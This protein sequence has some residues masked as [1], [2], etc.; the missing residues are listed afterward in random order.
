MSYTPL[1]IGNDL[2]DEVGNHLSIKSNDGDIANYMS[3]E[4]HG[5]G[6]AC[7]GK[8]FFD[9]YIDN[10]Y[11][12]GIPK[13]R[14]IK[15][16]V[17]E[18]YV[19][20]MLTN[21]DP[22]INYNIMDFVNWMYQY[23]NY[24]IL[25]HITGKLTSDKFDD[26][27]NPK[28]KPE[29]MSP[30][31]YV[32]TVNLVFKGGT[33]MH[34][35][36]NQIRTTMDHELAK[37][38]HENNTADIQRLEQAI[39][40]LVSMEDNFKPSDTDMCLDITASDNRRY[41]CICYAASDLIIKSME[42][43]S[44]DLEHLW[45][46]GHNQTPLNNL[47][48][49]CSAP[50]PANY[51]LAKHHNGIKEINTNEQIGMINTSRINTNV[52]ENVIHDIR[53]A[54]ESYFF[55]SK[56]KGF[57]QLWDM[58]EM[59]KFG[60]FSHNGI[61]I[62]GIHSIL[63]K[64][65]FDTNNRFVGTRNPSIAAVLIE[66]ID[67]Y[68]YYS[69]VEYQRTNNSELYGMNSKYFIQYTELR[70]KL[71]AIAKYSLRI[72]FEKISTIY[73]PSNIAKF[74]ADAAQNL[75]N[76]NKDL[77]GDLLYDPIKKA[78]FKLV[79]DDFKP[80]N[81]RTDNIAYRRDFIIHHNDNPLFTSR[82]V[83]CTRYNSG[84]SHASNGKHLHY[85]SVNKSIVNFFGSN[86]LDFNLFRIKLNTKVENLTHEVKILR[87]SQNENAKY[88]EKMLAVPL[89]KG[90]DPKTPRVALPQVEQDK[91]VSKVGVTRTV[92]APSEVLDI[93][94]NDK[95]DTQK[96]KKGHYYKYFHMR[97]IGGNDTVYTNMLTYSSRMHVADI[98]Y[99][100][101]EQSHFLPWMDIKY[102][103]RISRLFFFMGIYQQEL[104]HLNRTATGPH[105]HLYKL[106]EVLCS[107]RSTDINL[108]NLI[109][110]IDVDHPQNPVNRQLIESVLSKYTVL[111]KIFT[112]EYI[113][114]VYK[115]YPIYAI[116]QYFEEV[117]HFK[118]IFDSIIL[119]FSILFLLDDTSALDI[120][121]YNYDIL[122]NIYDRS[123][124]LK[125]T[126]D[127]YVKYIKDLK[128]IVVNKKGV[129][130]ETIFTQNFTVPL[131]LTMQ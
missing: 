63:T 52:F 29:S 18:A 50:K 35:I 111:G 61:N 55:L 46:R 60:D 48:R 92:L 69:L 107:N 80:D 105:S 22:N 117:S 57:C 85:I 5:K 43:I 33:T 8:V 94:I 14:A 66:L 100:L 75:S 68:K 103:K 113:Y 98:S 45:H 54:K 20:G 130:L 126:R 2:D 37:A 125:I 64:Y 11:L 87:T 15:D 95:F 53:M 91:I 102:K 70:A 27:V 118:D 32:E 123:T 26:P 44:G 131:G 39:K 28:V 30:L 110:S 21:P 65:A 101:F 72:L 127:D 51:E 86:K 13:I 78:F 71:D 23:I 17:T 73:Q 83:D 106:N 4:M 79:K 99:I 108:F 42:D 77:T 59:D 41:L 47:S 62:L 96:Y 31:N 6:N 3:I 129:G 24:Y 19:T 97:T 116:I 115:M 56:V 76:L 12:K 82:L 10:N 74:K 120:L 81:I 36:Y 16:K 89:P 124:L 121:T 128:D 122:H 9:D 1:I 34:V 119:M 90:A 84:E 88:S 93:T 49:V 25:T 58:L 104:E 67:F 112:P 7:I 114:T 109:K 38:V 40:V